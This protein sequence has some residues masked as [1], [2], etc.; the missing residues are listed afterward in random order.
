MA[1]PV[2]S[3]RAKVVKTRLPATTK[4]VLLTLATHMNDHGEGCFPGIKLLMAECSLSNRAVITHLEKA[5]DAGWI[6]VSK[7]G[8]SGQ[9]WARN[10]YRISEP[11]GSELESPPLEKAVNLMP[12]GGEPHDVKAVN[13]VHT[14]SSV[15]SS[16]N[17]SLPKQPKINGKRRSGLSPDWEIEE[18]DPCH[19]YAKSKGMTWAQMEIEEEQF[20][21]HHIAKG[22]VMVDWQAA[23]RTWVNNWVKFGK[24]NYGK[25]QG[26]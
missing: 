26:R 13:E 17:S 23:W 6:T 20:K 3:W 15:N 9:Q 21:N 12:E 1:I 24:G 7:H 8:F 4:L 11:K 18:D 2:L 22:N 5:R 14:N 25:T 16:V 10:D 19:L